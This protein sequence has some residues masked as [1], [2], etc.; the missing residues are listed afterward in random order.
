M[1]SAGATVIVAG[2]ASMLAF[3]TSTGCIDCDGSCTSDVHLVIRNPT[4]ATNKDG[5]AIFQICG[6]RCAS[7]RSTCEPVTFDGDV[8][9]PIRCEVRSDGLALDVF[10]EAEDAKQVTL[11]V[12]S[13]VDAVTPTVLFEA[14]ET[15]TQTEDETCGN[16][17]VQGEGTISIPP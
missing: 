10:M 15:L 4:N 1:L 14:N 3:S 7:F 12:R 8:N 9:H 11:T 2:L 6:T 16:T 13:G 5:G 17:C